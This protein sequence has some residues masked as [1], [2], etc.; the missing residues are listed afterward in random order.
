VNAVRAHWPDDDGHLGHKFN[1]DIALADDDLDFLREQFPEI[2]HVLDHP[3]LREEFAKHE[4][5]ANTSKRKVHKVG[6][7]AIVFAGVVL[8]GAAAKPILHLVHLPA[9]VGTVLVWL[10]VLALA[11][12]MIALGGFAIGKHKHKWLE[13]RM[14]TEILRAWHFQYMI[15]KGREIEQS[16][17][18][19]AALAVF[20]AQRKKEFEAFVHE[21]AGKADSYFQNLVENADVQ[22]VPLHRQQTQYS[23]EG[24]IREKVFIAY[25]MLRFQHQMTYAT[26]KLKKATDRQLWQLLKWPTRVLQDRLEFVARFCVVMSL[27]CSLVVIISHLSGADDVA[28]FVS[29]AIVALLVVNAIARTIQ[30]GLATP[31]E[32]ERYRDYQQKARYLLYGFEHASKP[33]EKLEFMRDMERAAVEELRSFLR[34]NEEA[35]FVM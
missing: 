7:L 34:A 10:E 33:E 1:D 25:R 18:D 30:D 19:D 27:A 11:A 29:V 3:D 20:R 12:A 31:K 6:L 8:L 2:L 13:A 4:K 24:G 16:C 9:L 5:V 17:G 15:Y 23:G 32:L 26:Y 28:A 14:M 22:Y 21:W 35:R